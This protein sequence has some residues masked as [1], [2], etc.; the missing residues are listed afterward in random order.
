LLEFQHA[1][2]QGVSSVSLHTL[3]P[4]V[5]LVQLPMLCIPVKLAVIQGTVFV[6]LTTTTSQDAHNILPDAS[7]LAVENLFDQE[8]P[9]PAQRG[10]RQRYEA[11]ENVN[12]VRRSQR[13]AI[14][15]AGFK[16]RESALEAGASAN[17]ICNLDEQFEATV[18]DENE[19]PPP[20]LPVAA[21][22]II[23]TTHCKMPPSVLSEEALNHN[24]DDDSD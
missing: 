4:S 17:V 13:L 5:T 16:N 19:E 14:K 7:S 23:G 24:S 12:S 15:K 1:I 22:Q 8:L 18:L 6:Q 3:A 20:H 9:V 21:L 11:P 10:N 2:R